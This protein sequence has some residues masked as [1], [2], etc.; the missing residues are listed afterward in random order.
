MSSLRVDVEAP[1]EK[2]R[3]FLIISTCKSFIPQEYLTDPNVFPER[4]EDKGSIYVEA[5]DKITLKKIRD[6][7]FVKVR[8]V[9]GVL[10]ESK[11]GNTNLR[12]R[13]IRGKIG[14]VYGIASTNSLANLIA[15]G[16]LTESDLVRIALEKQQPETERETSET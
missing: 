3:K 9:L 15:A 13:Q 6:I 5:S 7:T 2:F 4:L 14:R 8:D 11:S 10:Y 12:W 1:L 16:V